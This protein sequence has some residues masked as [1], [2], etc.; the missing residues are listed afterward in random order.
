MSHV[1]Y[2][3]S[4][5]LLSFWKSSTSSLT[6]VELECTAF[7]VRADTLLTS[8][9][10]SCA[11]TVRLLSGAEPPTPLDVKNPAWQMASCALTGTQLRGSSGRFANWI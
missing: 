11:S 8:A 1:A 5:L 4:V 7:Q 9:G 6:G 3:F 2:L 10:H